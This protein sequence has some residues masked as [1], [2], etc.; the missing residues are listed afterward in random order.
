MPGAFGRVADGNGWDT[1][2]RVSPFF[3]CSFTGEKE[4]GRETSDDAD[5]KR[6]VERFAVKLVY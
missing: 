4:G 1:R 6:V 3:S 2:E 5:V